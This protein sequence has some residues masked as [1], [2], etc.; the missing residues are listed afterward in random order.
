MVPGTDLLSP[1]MPFSTLHYLGADLLLLRR[2]TI[3]AGVLDC[4][5]RDGI[6]YLHS[7][8]STKI[9]KSSIYIGFGRRGWDRGVSSAAKNAR[10]HKIK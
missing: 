4:R 10:N 1:A 5:V 8:K 9:M 6:G 2:A 7:A 3:G